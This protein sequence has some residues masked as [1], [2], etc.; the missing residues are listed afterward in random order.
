MS[1]TLRSAGLLLALSVLA[2]GCT[3]GLL[4]VIS[5]VGYQIPFDPN[6]GW[7]AYFAQLAMRTGSPYP[8]AVGLLVNNYPPL[9]FYI[10]GG[11]ARITGDAIV[12]GR[13][14]SL[15]ALGVL[16]FGIVHAARL[17]GC[18]PRKAMFA[19]L[20]F[21]SCLLLTSDYVGMDDPQ[22]LGHA[23]AIWGLVIILRAPNNPRSMVFA[24]LIFTVAFF[25]KHN[26]IILP[27]ALA[28]WL[29]LANRRSA[30]TFIAAG[31]I[32]LLI[33]LGLFRDAFG[34][35]LFRQLSS[36]RIYS[37]VNVTMALENWLPWAALPLCG[38][39]ILIFIARR[40]RDTI[41]VLIY[42]AVASVGGV[43]F[44][45]GE[46]VDANAMFDADIALIL[47]AALLLDRL[48]R[49]I[50]ITVAAILYVVPLGFLLR[51]VDG[52]WTNSSYWLHPMAD[53]RR[54][55]AAEIS[56][57]RS[58]PEPVLCE[59]L[60]L[61][62]WADKTAEVDIFNVDQRI[63]A[64]IRSEVPLL[65][66]IKAKRFAMIE[67]ESLKPF[68]IAGGVE[69]AVIRNYKIVRR[70]DERVFLSPR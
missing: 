67:L 63:R 35:D 56:L 40:D 36:A 39:I 6:E 29:M 48:G 27:S 24:A 20:L 31:V 58:S 60:S 69:Q 64:D 53:E 54:A 3:A 1:A 43:L 55:A 32:F 65:G 68:P 22:L 12:A 11:I 47:C 50:W 9:S 51:N 46:G 49:E 34:T 41:L 42:V 17:M 57:L 44:S 70:D 14:V 21:V 62:Y 23:I 30:L 66:M 15:L 19:A 26:L 4:H 59:M 28:L 5:V 10:I 2:L 45:S 7:N 13:L 18:A 61:C 16:S 38:A 25:V 37:L 52:D 33:G 8:P